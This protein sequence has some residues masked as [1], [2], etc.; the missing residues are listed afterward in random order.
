[1]EVV[2][3]VMGCVVKYYVTYKEGTNIAMQASKPP[4]D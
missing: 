1:M 3:A 4:V 2:A